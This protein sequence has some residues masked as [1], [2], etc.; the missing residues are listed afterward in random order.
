[1]LIP[2]L[3]EE[4]ALARVPL[5]R[6]LDSPR[7]R[8]FVAAYTAFL[9]GGP[10]DGQRA[11]DRAVLAA[12][13]DLIARRYAAVRKAGDRL[14]KA[15]PPA[16]Y[17]ALRIRC[18]RLRYAAQCFAPLYGQPARAMARR[19]AAVQDILGLQQ[20]A[21]V[22]LRTLHRLCQRR[23]RRLPPATLFALGQAAAR[24]A[25][26]A[27]EARAGFA[28]AYHGLAGKRWKRLRDTIEGLRPDT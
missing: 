15:S 16:A 23:G 2:L 8:R 14:T 20:D 10:R 18:K 26:Q 22:A 3:A 12:A 17:H 6:V 19:A 25:Q 27:A 4:R 9:R 21:Q 28:R 1:V 11:A 24:F 13:P 7:Y 5:L